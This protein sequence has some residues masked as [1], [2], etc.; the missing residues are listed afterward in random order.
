MPEKSL[1]LSTCSPC[2]G[3]NHMPLCHKLTNLLMSSEPLFCPLLHY[4]T[5]CARHSTTLPVWFLQP[6]APPCYLLLFLSLLFLFLQPPTSAR[7]TDIQSSLGVHN[8]SLPHHHP[9][10]LQP[11]GYQ[12]LHNLELFVTPSKRVLVRLKQRHVG[13]QDF[14][15]CACV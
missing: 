5:T 9:T 7:A 3:R 1:P 15:L 10:G 6:A 8:N 11:N 4:I 13:V 12:R 2:G 14:L